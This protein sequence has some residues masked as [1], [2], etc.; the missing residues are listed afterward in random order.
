MTPYLKLDHIDKSFTRGSQVTEVLRD[1]TLGVANANGIITVHLAPS[2]IAVAL[3]LEFDD[4]L[5]TPEIEVKV[6]EIE[7]QLRQL[8]PGVVSVFIK[9]QSSAGYREAAARHIATQALQSGKI[10]STAPDGTNVQP[11]V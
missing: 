9:P 4:E 11:Q 5:R 10:Q 7:R 3:S 8:H 6:A 2:Q 1:I